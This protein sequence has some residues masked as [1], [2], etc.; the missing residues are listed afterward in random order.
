VSADDVRVGRVPIDSI[1][2]HQHNVRVDLG[3][4][5][6]LT[7]SIQR[8]GVMQPVVLE[9][10][11]DRLRIRAGHRRVAAAR[12]AGLTR[13]PALIHGDALEDD[14]WLTAAVHENTRRRGL[15]DADRARTVNAMRTEGMTWDAIGDAFGVTAATARRYLADPDAGPAPIDELTHARDERWQQ[16][17]DQVLA[18]TREGRSAAE[19]GNQ[20]GMSKRQVARYRVDRRGTVSSP[21]P[22]SLLRN[23]GQEAQSRIDAGTWTAQDVVL[24]VL[25]LADHGTLTAALSAGTTTQTGDAA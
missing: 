22:R 20:L 10:R 23:L 4:L 7:T 15:D 9:R 24:A 19:I 2:Y 1:D 8:F 21:V 17:R 13:I 16:Q 14:E 11:G 18:L 3:D 12:L 25:R 6:D 5:R